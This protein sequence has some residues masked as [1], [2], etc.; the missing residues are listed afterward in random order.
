MPAVTYHPDP[1]LWKQVNSA[2]FQATIH[3]LNVHPWPQ[4]EHGPK[5]THSLWNAPNG[6]T[7]GISVNTG[8]KS[9]DYY[10]PIEMPVP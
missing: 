10:V 9:W 4:P 1:K 3:K 2:Q 7:R 6:E 8:L 5:F